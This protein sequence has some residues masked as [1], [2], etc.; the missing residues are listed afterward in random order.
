MLFAKSNFFELYNCDNLEL[1]NSIGGNY[2]DM[3]Y[4]DVL[5]GTGRDFGVYRDIKANK[6]S[7]YSHYKPRFIEMQRVL[8][9]S[10]SIYIHCDW[11]INHWIRLMMDDVFD[12]KNLINEL[13]WCYRSG[14]GSKKAFR[15]QHDTIYLYG[16]SKDYVFNMQKIRAPLSHRYGFSNI[17]EFYD[18]KRGEWYRLANSKS[19]IEIDVVPNKSKSDKIVFPTQKP[20]ALAELFVKTS[21]NKGD[22]IGDFYMGSGSTG[23]AAIKNERFF[24][25][26]DKSK[27][28]CEIAKQRLDDIINC[29]VFCE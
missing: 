28:A 18:K 5:Y 2:F 4:C 12:Y 23:V 24:I 1:L 9:P 13:V 7:V 14:G 8:K 17:E 16:K 20:V 15:R 26:C 22:I 25:G 10:G 27:D 19:W 6:E 21:T 3:I 11:R 29:E